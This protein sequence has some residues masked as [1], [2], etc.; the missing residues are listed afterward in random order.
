ML[1]S[2]VITALRG[3][4]ILAKLALTVLIGREMGL[5]DLG[6]FGLISA[7]VILVPA[8]GSL[9]LMSLVGRDLV[10]HQPPEIVRDLKHYCLAVA[11]FYLLATV[12]LML[13]ASASGG[14]ATVVGLTLVLILL[15]HLSSDTITILNNLGRYLLANVILFI[16]S[17]AWMVVFIVGLWLLP[18][19]ATMESLL[20][21][22]A[23]ACLACVAVFFAVTRHWP[24]W[25]AGMATP[26]LGWYRARWRQATLLLLNDV[27]NNA[28]LYVDRYVIVLF[29]GLEASGIYLFFWSAINAA[30][31]VVQTGVVAAYRR[32]LIA[33]HGGSPS[34]FRTAFRSIFR[35]S[36]ILTILLAVGLVIVVPLVL[37]LLDQ[38]EAMPFVPL[39]WVLIGFLFVR[40]GFDLAGQGLYAAHRDRTLVATAIALLPASLVCNVA[41]LPPL[42]LYGAAIAGI[43]STAMILALRFHSLRAY[44]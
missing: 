39:L 43:A 4:S 29:L 32:R 35:Q 33:A 20:L 14:S 21:F 16:K 18:E 9:G 41:L 37:P 25:T 44:L 23:A 10:S 36:L 17:G 26:V 3:L 11:I 1:N 5:D 13:L 22:W 40:V 27:S 34:E 7:A 2:L 15:E 8:L 30:F 42:G 12:P 28:A 31:S 38:P 6:L 24:W 19:I